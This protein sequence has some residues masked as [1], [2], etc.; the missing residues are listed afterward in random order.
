M[1]PKMGGQT[2][3]N[4]PS[5]M[6]TSVGVAIGPKMGGATLIATQKRDPATQ[7]RPENRV[8][9]TWPLTCG[10]ALAAKAR[11]ERDPSAD[12]SATPLP[13]L[14]ESGKG[15]AVP[16]PLKRPLRKQAQSEPPSDIDWAEVTKAFIARIRTDREA[17]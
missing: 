3:L 11:P 17:T 5:E 2:A 10:Y 14:G 6:S 9:L 8:A 7:A 16:G 15:R 13:T 12:S 1:T 4:L